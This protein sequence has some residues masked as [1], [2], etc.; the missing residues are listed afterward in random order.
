M[1]SSTIIRESMRLMTTPH[2]DAGHS[3]CH[4]TWRLAGAKLALTAIR[5]EPGKRWAHLIRTARFTSSHRGHLRVP[6]GQPD[7]RVRRSLTLAHTASAVVPGGYCSIMRGPS[8]FQIGAAG[9]GR[10]LVG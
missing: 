4:R 8:V 9:N 1:T 10:D 2:D 6:R 7:Y 3:V 5:P